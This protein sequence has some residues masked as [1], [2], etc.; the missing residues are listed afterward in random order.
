MFLPVSSGC[1]PGSGNIGAGR[2]L[3]MTAG[4]MGYQTVQNN[5]AYGLAKATRLTV[6]KMFLKRY[7][8]DTWPFVRL[9]TRHAMS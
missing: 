2:G 1:I 4:F 7:P 5:N 6:K 8:S 3:Q 9:T